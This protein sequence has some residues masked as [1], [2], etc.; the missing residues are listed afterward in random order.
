[1]WLRYL[2]RPRP[3]YG[4]AYLDWSSEE[5]G[6]GAVLSGDDAMLAAYVSGDPYLTFAKQVGAIPPDGTRESHGPIRD[7]FKTICLGVNYGM[8]AD[9]L[10]SRL[11][12][13]VVE[14]HHFLQLYRETYRQ[15][16]RWSGGAVDHAMARGSIETIFGWRLWVDS[17]PNP[18]SL[19]N[20]P[21]QANRAELLRLAC[22]LATERGVRVAAPVHDALL[23][24]APLSDI[25]H[26]VAVTE[27]AMREA[28]R[29]VLKGFE[30]RVDRKL[31]LFPNRFM[32]RRGEVMWHTVCSI[33]S[34]LEQTA[35]LSEAI[36]SE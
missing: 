14:A 33:L 30:L 26:H 34:E 12:R 9:S 21:L 23:V 17:N 3:G 16:W 5:F 35:Q 8:G 25:E 24:E 19:R 2:I 13:P 10:A 15:Y 28:S 32:D 31:I 1:V 7:L 18:R 22:C 6:I 27:A 11:A 4:L 20:F 29:A 36:L